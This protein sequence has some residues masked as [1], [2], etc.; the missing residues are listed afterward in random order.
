MAG[1]HVVQHVE[2]DAIAVRRRVIAVQSIYQVRRFAVSSILLA[3][4]SDS[5][6]SDAFLQ[7]AHAKTL[8]KSACLT[9]LSSSL[10]DLAFALSRTRVFDVA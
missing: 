1:A 6:Q 8:L 3:T 9:G 10:V 2:V 5:V 7:H 4:A